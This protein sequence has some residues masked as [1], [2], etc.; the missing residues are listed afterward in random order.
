MDVQRFDAAQFQWVGGDNFT[1]NPTVTVERRVNGVWQPY[2]DQSGEV[3]VFLDKPVDVVSGLPT[4]AQGQQAWHWRAS[5]EAFDSYPRADVP[6][7][8]VPDGAYHFVVHGNI[9][10]A[11]V[12]VPYDVT[13]DTFMVTPWT[14]IVVHGLRRDSDSTVSFVV[15]PIAYPRMP[16]PEH[17]QG[18]LPSMYKDDL[19]GNTIC[20]SCTFRPWATTGSVASVGVTVT[21]KNGTHPR[22]VT[23][24]YDAASG[25]WIASVPKK[26]GQTVT[27]PAGGVRDTYGEMNGDGVA[28]GE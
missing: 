2:A 10:T 3:Q 16:K 28:F 6:G 14:G 5:F 11:G 17:R 26:K 4:Y 19:A 1:D 8:Q 25:R 24:S 21:G 23:A 7:G 15:D 20:H 27:V 12:V 22:T 9:H 13:S 18:L